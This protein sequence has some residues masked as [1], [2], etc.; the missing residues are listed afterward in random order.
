MPESSASGRAARVR[1]LVFDLDGTLVDGYDAI[2]DGVNAARARFGLPALAVDDVRGRVGAGL[3]HLMEDVVGAERA[4][5]GADIFR[6]VY[7]AVAVER[8][9]PVER[10]EET[11]ELLEAR[12]FRMSVAS[13][14]PV[15][16]SLRILESLGVARRFDLVAGPE[17][18]GALKPDPA[19]IRAC[20]TAMSV[21]PGEAIYVG[22]MGLDAE[23]GA[24][25]GVDVVLVTGG[26]TPRHELERTGCPV[27]EGL[28][29]LTAWLPAR[30]AERSRHGA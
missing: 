5:E 9:R 26:S 6:R 7:D 29:A 8:T 24:R 17:T 4:A 21:A 2:A 13:N 1:G 16:Y 18:A 3:I 10:L 22:D 27:V 12:G 28:H 23:S 19:M 11:L 15:G 30:A 14:K 25:A 20:L